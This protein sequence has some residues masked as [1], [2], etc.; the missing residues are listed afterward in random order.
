MNHSMRYADTLLRTKFIGY[1]DFL[2]VV[3][4]FFAVK[5]YDE[6]FYFDISKPARI[7]LRLLKPK[8][9]IKPFLFNLDEIRNESGE[10]RIVK[11][12]EKDLNDVCKELELNLLHK[13]PFIN[14]FG[15][16]FNKK[17][18]I[19]YFKKRLGFEIRNVVIFINVVDWYLNQNGGKLKST[20]EFSIESNPCFRVLKDF[21]SKE[22]DI[23]L[24]S[25]F[26]IRN[27]FKFVY[28]LVGNLYLSAIAILL[29]IY[30][31]IKYSYQFQ[32][33]RTSN[34]IPVLATQY[35]PL[36]L[37][38]DMTKRVDF[39]WLL[40]SKIP[41][42]QVLVYFVRPDTPATDEMDHILRKNGVKSLA[43]SEAAT[44]TSKIPVYRP[45]M[46]LTEILSRLTGSVILQVF[47]ELFY[48][49]LESLGYL[50]GAF[51]FVRE[52]SKTYDFYKSAG[53]KVDV[54]NADSAY[55]DIPRWLALEAVGGVSVSYQRSHTAVRQIFLA[56]TADVY[57]HFGPYYLPLSQKYEYDNHATLTCGYITDYSFATVKK[58]SKALRKKI[59]AMGGKFIICYFDENSSDDRLSLIPNRKSAY[60]YERLLR[61]VI[62]DETIGL[63]CSPKR[64]ANLNKRLSNIAV[65]MEKA[66]ATGRC[67][68]MG[69]DYTASNY[70]A[71]T[72]QASDIVISLLLGGTTA[73]ESALSGQRVIYLD[74]E[75]LYS[76]PE[77]GLGKDTTVFD[78][79]DNMINA[80]EKYRCDPKSF[81][82]LGNIDM[83]PMLK[84]KDPFRDGKAA[85]RIGQYLQW[86]L[87]SFNKG[88]TREE[89][90]KCAN[91][92]YAQMWGAE[93]VHVS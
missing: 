62:A 13:S 27:V 43:K 15:A 39:F 56:S 48:F 26:S 8:Q 47:K 77:Y 28:H 85:E 29:P 90:I 31:S 22:Y 38:F 65:L 67:I 93:N 63:I 72:A 53:I 51:Y 54:Y 41:Y 19:F 25:Y 81:D 40:N 78:N 64:P 60:V 73:L 79:L 7:L 4:L 10:S 91:R 5:L 11:V 23:A 80:I 59:T 17:K 20:I 86:L 82:K 89:A 49:R 2:C 16:K 57:F 84:E 42:A 68:F 14:K 45:S 70:P 6:I 83:M 36:G 76:F 50:A 9:A 24:T 12:L 46:T 88:E 34:S 35:Q 71:E 18:V 37:T 74:L 58:R 69:G 32:G 52:Y 30:C 66:K 55:F 61:W 75:G 1:L 92:N 3:K 21:A 33:R 44:R 87:E